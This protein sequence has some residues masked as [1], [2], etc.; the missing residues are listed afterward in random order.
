VTALLRSERRVTYRLLT[1]ACGL[2]EALLKAVRRELLFKQVACD[3]DGEGLVWTGEP[4]AARPPAAPS[5]RQP[6]LP[7]P[8]GIA[9]AAYPAWSAHVAAPAGSVDA[10]DD[11]RVPG[12]TRPASE[13]E[14]RQL[15]VLF[16]DLVG[17][18]QLSGQLDP[19]DL[20]EV[21]R[22]Y[23]ETAAEVIQHYEGHIAQYLGDGLLVYF[24]YPTAHEDEARRAVYTGLGIVQAMATL[25]TRLAAQYGVQLAVRLGIHTGPVVVGVM[26]GGGRHEHLALGETPNIAARLEGLAPANAVVISAV[27]ARLVLGTFALED[28]GTHALHGVAAPMAVSRVRGLLATP[29]PDEAFVTATVSVL[30]GREEES[31]LL[32]RRWEQ[33]KAGLGQVVFMS[34]EAGIG[35]SALVEGLRAQVRAEGLPRMALRCSPYHTTSA[36]YPV[37]THLEHLWQSAPDDP[38]ATKLVKLEAGLRP[39]GLPLAEVVPLFAGLL[40]VPL[41]AERY[42]PLTVTPQHQKQQTLDALLAWLA[43]EAER[44]PVLMAWEDLYWADPTTLEVLGLVIEQAPTVPMLHVLISRPAFSPPWPPRSHITPLVLNRLERPQVEALITQ[45]AGGKTL[46]AEVVHHI[47]A[48]TDRVPLYVEE[49]TKMLLVSALLREEVDQYVLI[50][51]LCTVAIPDHLTGC[52]HGPPGSAPDGQ[53][54]GAARRGAGAGVSV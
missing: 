15:T 34:G 52:A 7:D 28:L 48:K 37:I 8:A 47:V 35:K 22:A 16:C 51:P 4:D 49:L 23:Q 32:R 21:V 14:R 11:V 24:G 53:R 2:D 13:A 44:Q 19:E 1:L 33:S 31:G 38:P 10:Q 3:V 40:A 50:G 36:L 29:S 27:T 46:P 9:A 39:S 6:A 41:P 26:G 42:A 12:P 5:M 45:R 20:R 18:T 25:N 43:A 17:S 54:G 30:V